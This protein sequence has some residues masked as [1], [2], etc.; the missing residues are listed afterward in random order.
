MVCFRAKRRENF[1]L[2]F[3]RSAEKILVLLSRERF[4][5]LICEGV[6]NTCPPQG[7]LP[8]LGT[9][10]VAEEG[11]GTHACRCGD[12]RV[13]G[14]SCKVEKLNGALRQNVVKL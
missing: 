1:D 8:L 5:A 11:W 7:W 4:I 14:A 6:G 12:Y 2:A 9:V 13:Y 10:F 3:A